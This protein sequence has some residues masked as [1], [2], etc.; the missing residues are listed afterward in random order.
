[1][2]SQ[3]RDVV[4]QHARNTADLPCF[5]EHYRDCPQARAAADQVLLLPTYPKYGEVE[6]RKN[7]AVIRQFF[8]AD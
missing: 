3:G 4:V 2:I 8:N 6:V 7:I 5:A 1:M